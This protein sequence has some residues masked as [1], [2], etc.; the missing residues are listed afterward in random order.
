MIRERESGKF[1]TPFGEPPDA[2]LAP[3]ALWTVPASPPIALEDPSLWPQTFHPHPPPSL[4][5]FLRCAGEGGPGCRGGG[6]PSTQ[7]GGGE[8]PPTGTWDQTHIWGHST[9]STAVLQPIVTTTLPPAADH[10]DLC[11]TCS[12]SNFHTTEAIF[13]NVVVSACADGRPSR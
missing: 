7:G 11:L 9:F 1:R 13:T 8:V 6:V 5:R 12:C 2:G 4:F 3:S 10:T